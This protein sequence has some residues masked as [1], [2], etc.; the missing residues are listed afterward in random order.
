MWKLGDV[1]LDGI[2]KVKEPFFSK[3]EQGGC[4]EGLCNGPP[5]GWRVG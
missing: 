3:H 4:G 5:I 1:F 2:L